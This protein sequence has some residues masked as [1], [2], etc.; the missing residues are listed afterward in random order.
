[1]SNDRWVQLD[2]PADVFIMTVSL[3]FTLISIWVL[4]HS[5]EFQHLTI[6]TCLSIYRNLPQHII[7]QELDIKLGPFTLEELDSVLR[8]N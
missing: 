7:S 8:K 4:I 5:L 3:N 2:K 6:E 1:M